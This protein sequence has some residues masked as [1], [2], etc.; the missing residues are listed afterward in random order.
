M[1]RA[2]LDQAQRSYPYLAED[3]GT[4]S[5]PQ[6]FPDL[7]GRKLEPYRAVGNPNTGTVVE[8]NL[9]PLGVPA[10]MET[11]VDREKVASDHRSQENHALLSREGPHRSQL[12]FKGLLGSGESLEVAQRLFYPY[13]PEHRQAQVG[14]GPE[15][16]TLLG[17]GLGDP[18]DSFFRMGVEIEFYCAAHLKI[19]FAQRL[20]EQ[21]LYPDLFGPAVEIGEVEVFS[22][23]LENCLNISLLLV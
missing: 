19:R 16:D 21:P 18:Q 5:D 4:S 7:L 22:L 1:H 11:L 15:A 12:E 23:H 3:L 2:K 17:E 20:L 10:R 8:S 6:R 13:P 14:P 9:A